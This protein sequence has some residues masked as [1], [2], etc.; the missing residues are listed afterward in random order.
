[1][2]QTVVVAFGG[3]SPEHEVS[4]ITAAQV[5]HAL[6]VARYTVVPLYITKAGAWLTGD[7]LRNLSAFQDLKQLER[8]CTA[9]HLRIGDN[10]RVVLQENTAGG[11]FSKPASYAVD[12]VIPAFHGADGE[13]GAFQG[14]CESWNI[15][16]T[17]SGVMASALGMDK[18]AAKKMAESAGIPVVPSV[19]FFEE[20]W[21]KDSESL[22]TAIDKLPYP[23]FVKPARLGSSIG[24]MR[25]DT[26]AALTDTIETAFR[27]DPKV[28]VEQGITPLMEINCA[29]LGTPESAIPSV[30][31][32]P[33]NKGDLL[34]FEDKYLGER[35]SGK[36]MASLDRLIPAP[37]ADALRDRIQDLAVRLFKTLN[38]SGV[39][40]LDF[41][42]NTATGDVFFN[43][44]NTIP[45]SFSF[46]L[47]D[48]TGIGFPALLERM[49]GIAHVQHRNK[50]GRVRSYETNLL[51]K[52][53]AT[54]IKG[55]KFKK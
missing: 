18:P 29:V 23:L 17:G 4:V 49:I 27:Y 47:W 52:K 26:P 32:Q 8:S 54:G 12:V 11:L 42:V 50:N 16:Y 24:V 39:A 30:C 25:V 41:L 44:I 22:R 43:E 35:G 53:A 31:E 6:D 5:M 15:P 3:V 21:V 45:G 19:S 20:D 55:L 1:M 40:R 7:M 38:C 14:M 51:S 36:G 13:N 48:K 2:K 46:Y 10:G 33:V 9:C 28:L 34:S 37:I